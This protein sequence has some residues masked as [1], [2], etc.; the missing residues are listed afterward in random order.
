MSHAHKLKSELV[1]TLC[2]HF[3]FSLIFSSH[4]CVQHWANHGII[5][6]LVCFYTTNLL[7][8]GATVKPSLVHWC[9]C[10]ERQEG[11]CCSVPTGEGPTRGGAA[12]TWCVSYRCAVWSKSS[13]SPRET[14]CNLAGGGAQVSR[15]NNSWSCESSSAL[16]SPSLSL[17]S[18]PSHLIVHGSVCWQLSTVSFVLA[19][20]CSL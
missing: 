9:L 5:S 18:Y 4:S 15:T 19:Q 20:T 3:W 7:C 17:S 13:Y 10:W 11:A 16:G 14:N 6:F 8:R 12:D 1:F 2:V